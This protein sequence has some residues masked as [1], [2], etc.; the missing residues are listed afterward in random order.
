[1]TKS[2]LIRRRLR[3]PVCL[4]HVR[5][6]KRKQL[7]QALL[8]VRLWSLDHLGLIMEESEIEGYHLLAVGFNR[9]LY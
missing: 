4:I 2:S 8:F 1:M 7:T 6:D 3:H 9:S 5:V